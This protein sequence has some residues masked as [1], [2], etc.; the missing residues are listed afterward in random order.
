[1]SFFLRITR[2][3]VPYE[4]DKLVFCHPYPIWLND[5]NGRVHNGSLFIPITGQRIEY[6]LRKTIENRI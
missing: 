4:P 6:V 5:Q 1:M 2:L 3:T